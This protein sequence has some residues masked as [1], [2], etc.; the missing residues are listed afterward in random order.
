MTALPHTLTL[1]TLALWCLLSVRVSADPYLYLVADSRRPLLLLRG[2]SSPF[3]PRT[4][5]TVQGR[6]GQVP[7]NKRR[8]SLSPDAEYE[9]EMEDDSSTRQM[10]D[11]FLTRD[12]RN[13]FI[14]TLD[15]TWS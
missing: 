9:E 15:E 11:A 3:S 14:G 5:P 6:P 10:I 4:P 13:S 7:S 1:L 2:G 8:T 12:S